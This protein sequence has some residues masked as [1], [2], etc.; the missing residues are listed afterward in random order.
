MLPNLELQFLVSFIY[1][2]VIHSKMDTSLNHG[3]E[4]YSLGVSATYRETR[5]V[6]LVYQG[7]FG[8]VGTNPS[9]AEVSANP[10]DRAYISLSLQHTF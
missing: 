2:F 10:T 9:V 1:H 4:N 7:C 3:T 8:Q 5:D 6:T